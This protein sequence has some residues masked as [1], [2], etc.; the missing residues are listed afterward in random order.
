MSTFKT[1]YKRK[2]QELARQNPK[3]SASELLAAVS[4][5]AGEKAASPCIVRVW[6]RNTPGRA[7]GGKTFWTKERKDEMRRLLIEDMWTVGRVVRHLADTFKYL[8]SPDT[9]RALIPAGVPYCPEINAENYGSQW[10]DDVRAMAVDLIVNQGLTPSGVAKRLHRANG[11]APGVST[12]KKWVQGLYTPKAKIT[13]MQAPAAESCETPGDSWQRAWDAAEGKTGAAWAETVMRHW[14][15]D[16]E[17]N[18]DEQRMQKA[19]TKR[20]K[21]K[22]AREQTDAATGRRLA[23]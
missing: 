14:L 4:P 8:A 6:I 20:R 9:V 12:I 13:K 11:H 16:I 15:P 22:E 3:M 7:P 17:R 19:E 18:S 5:A 23:A 1:G 21:R 10:G 2:I